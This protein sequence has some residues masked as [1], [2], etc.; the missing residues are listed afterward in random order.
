MH[1]KSKL[2]LIYLYP[3]IIVI[4]HLFMQ[5]SFIQEN[6]FFYVMGISLLIYT[7][8][9]Y[10]KNKD[11]IMEYFVR[12]VYF[13]YTYFFLLYILPEVNGKYN[14]WGNNGGI[15]NFNETVSTGIV[16]FTI[17]FILYVTIISDFHISEV[18]LGNAKITMLKEKYD[19]EINS[20][21]KNT[22]QLLEKIEAEGEII[23]NMKEYC[24]RV[25]D[26]IDRGGTYV[27]EEY[28]ILITEYF[29]R[30]KEKIKVSVLQNLEKKE[31]KED[32]R[33][34]S[35][36]I[37][38]LKY[39]LEHKALYS[40]ESNNTYYLFIPFCYVFEELLNDEERPVYIVLESKTPISVEAESNIIRNILIKF[41]DDLL[42]LL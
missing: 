39:Q 24:L 29:N 16:I 33:L 7:H 40:T 13:I 22:N 11:K 23:Y 20:H 30:Q 14:I 18:S 10:K 25:K 19:V 6:W 2:M 4:A 35:G 27:S 34:K 36:E 38:I 28:Q 15:L 1:K 32:F 12:K 5:T 3:A 9:S 17:S 26:R 21:F 37:D 31:L 8:L 41:T 42:E